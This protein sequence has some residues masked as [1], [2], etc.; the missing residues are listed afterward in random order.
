MRGGL[1]RRE[2]ALVLEHRNAMLRACAVRN[3][4]ART[5]S[6]SSSHYVMPHGAVARTRWKVLESFA[7]LLDMVHVP[8]PTNAPPILSPRNDLY[9]EFD[10]L[11][12]IYNVY[13]VS[14]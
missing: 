2:R 8:E 9:S 5:S 4:R 1:P 11:V 7:T 10:D 6:Y 12:S 3:T 13:K 14:P